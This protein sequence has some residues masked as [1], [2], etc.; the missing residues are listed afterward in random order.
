MPVEQ[1]PHFV[2][3]TEAPEMVVDRLRYFE[4]RISESPTDF[5]H[6]LTSLGEAATANTLH[7]LEA[8]T[9]EVSLQRE[10][11]ELLLEFFKQRL[12]RYIEYDPATEDALENDAERKQLLSDLRTKQ[13]RKIRENDRIRMAPNL[14]GEIIRDTIRRNEL[15]FYL[16]RVVGWQM[17]T[18]PNQLRVS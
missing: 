11:K 1:R 16:Q 7:L 10:P 17:Q 15:A 3:D 18:E 8:S 9:P 4:T 13:P 6:T 14:D 12:D 2:I 5:S